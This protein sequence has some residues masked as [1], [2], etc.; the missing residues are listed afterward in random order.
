MKNNTAQ[1]K[2]E[3]ISDGVLSIDDT[4]GCTCYLVEGRDK[5]LLIDT[6]CADGDFDAMLR[7][8]TNLPV[9]LLLTHFHYDHTRH[10]AKFST[11]HM[12]R[13]DAALLGNEAEYGKTPPGFDPRLNVI[14]HITD[15]GKLD[16]GGGV[17]ATLMNLTGHTPGS[18]A[19]LLEDRRIL[20]TGDAIGSG[21]GV[22]MQLPHSR[23]VSQYAANLRTFLARIEKFPDL[24]I[25]G[26]HIGQAGAPGSA[27][28]NPLT[29]Q[30]IRD[31][32]ELCDMIARGEIKTDEQAHKARN[33]T[34]AMLYLPSRI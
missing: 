24:R 4:D 10:A 29:T 27:T 11:I 8:L 18:V 5:A 34:A 14:T 25:F 30:T 6:G 26:G 22:W 31:M 12:R 17:T 3:R 28:Y 20:F 9:E 32:I 33:K 2:I 15:G 19:V 16:L 7:G 23:P 13:E 21:D 1:Y